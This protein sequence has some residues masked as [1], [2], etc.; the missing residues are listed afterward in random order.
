MHILLQEFVHWTF[1]CSPIKTQYYET[2]YLLVL[3][4]NQRCRALLRCNETSIWIF[5]FT[6]LALVVQMIN[7]AIHWVKWSLSRG[8]CNWLLDSTKCRL[9]TDCVLL[10]LGLENNRTIVVTFSFAWWKQ[11]PAAVCSLHFV[12]TE[13]ASLLPNIYWIVIYPPFKQ[14]ELCHLIFIFKMRAFLLAL[15][16]F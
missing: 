12:W 2:I 8:K 11:W 13:L 4:H 10:F 3:G 5:L 1:L 14:V 7:K 16:K 15:A 6:T 9:H